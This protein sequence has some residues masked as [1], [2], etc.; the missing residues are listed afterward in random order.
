MMLGGPISGPTLTRF[1]ALARVCYSGIS[2]ACVGLHLGWFCGSA[3][4]MACRDDVRRA[5]CSRVSRTDKAD[6][7]SFCP[8]AAWKDAIFASADYAVGYACALLFDLW[9]YGQPDP[10]NHPDRAEA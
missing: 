2:L 3:L 8:D 9:T 4:M 10:T 6:R 1:F 7:N 5:L